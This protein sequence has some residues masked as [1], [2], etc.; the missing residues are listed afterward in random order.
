[1]LLGLPGVVDGD[2]ELVVVAAG[3]GETV[4]E[5]EAMRQAAEPNRA[6][7]RTGARRPSIV[8]IGKSPVKIL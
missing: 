1:V 4:S 5:Q 2:V 8:L 7:L 3:G 6:I